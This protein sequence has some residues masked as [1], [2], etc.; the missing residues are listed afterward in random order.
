[1][2]CVSA[3][4][5]YN[6]DILLHIQIYCVVQVFEGSVSVIYDDSA[7]TVSIEAS[8]VTIHPITLLSHDLQW[9][10]DSMTDMYADG[11]LSVILQVISDPD[12][13]QGI[14]NVQFVACF[15]L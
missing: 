15:S 5:V 12:S 7:Q 9:D 3:V 2:I 13:I 11:V 14:H 8:H 1:M 6:N 10:A 4:C